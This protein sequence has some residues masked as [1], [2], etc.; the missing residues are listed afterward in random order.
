[1]TRTAGPLGK[2]RGQSKLL[3]LRREAQ[4]IHSEVGRQEAA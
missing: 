3:L 4:G 2:G 1:M